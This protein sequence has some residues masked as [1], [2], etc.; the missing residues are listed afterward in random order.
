MNFEAPGLPGRGGKAHGEEVADMGVDV[1]PRAA[2]TVHVRQVQVVGEHRSQVT[3]ALR[4]GAGEVPPEFEESLV[5]ELQ[6][7][8]GQRLAIAVLADAL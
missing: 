2:T 4:P 7:V 6:V 8:A 1:A 5:D 3:G